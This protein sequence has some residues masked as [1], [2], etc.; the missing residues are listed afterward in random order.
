MVGRAVVIH[1]LR[2]GLVTSIMLSSSSPLN[3]VGRRSRSF[4]SASVSPSCG[5]NITL[6]SVLCFRLITQCAAKYSSHQSV[7][8]SV[9]T[10]LHVVKES[11]AH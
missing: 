5:S 4:S 2:T 7:S 8:Q 3:A 9:K 11:E 1:A 10:H 6:Q